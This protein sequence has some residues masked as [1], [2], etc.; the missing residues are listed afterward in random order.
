MFTAAC[1]GWV[2]ENLLAGGFRTQI[3]AHLSDGVVNL[4]GIAQQYAG[5]LPESLP[6]HCGGVRAQ[7]QRRA[8]RQRRGACRHH[9]GKEYYQPLLTPVIN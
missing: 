1:A 5:F 2:F 4:S 9:R 8:G 7:H 6:F 3:A